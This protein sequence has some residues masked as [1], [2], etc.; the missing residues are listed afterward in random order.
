MLPKEDAMLASQNMM[1]AAHSMGLGTC[2]IGM[3]V[4]A[5]KRD[6]SIPR[7]VGIPDEET[8]YAVVALGHP[9]EKYRTL[10]GRKKPIVR[11]FER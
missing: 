4:E 1:L 5:M 9:D 2:L 10:A 7:S 11:F 8:V 6:R 3:A